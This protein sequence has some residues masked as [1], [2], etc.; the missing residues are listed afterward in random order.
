[1]FSTSLDYAPN[2]CRSAGP[3][4]SLSPGVV[5]KDSPAPGF[6]FY[7][8]LEFV[9]TLLAAFGNQLLYLLKLLD[10]LTVAW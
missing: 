6:L 3:M 4:A 1:M 5:A 7:R 9:S 2:S 8:R 10:H